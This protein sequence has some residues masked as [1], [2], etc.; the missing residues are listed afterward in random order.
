MKS[1]VDITLLPGVDIT[2]YFLWEKVYQQL[3]LALVE[4]QDAKNNIKVGVAFPE[5]DERKFQLGNKLRVFAP[6]RVDL[7]AL[8]INHWLAGLNDYVHITSIR[9]VPD[10]IEGYAHFKRIQRKSN[11]DRLARRR[12]KRK[13][14][15]EEEAKAYFEKREEQYSQAPFIQVKSHSSDKRYRLLISREEAESFQTDNGFSTYGLSSSSSVPL[16]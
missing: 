16:F 7:E 4:C 13:G 3:H 2:L 9:D 5:Y 15:S 6:F 11:N 14:I 10:K 12:A 1:Y 8:N